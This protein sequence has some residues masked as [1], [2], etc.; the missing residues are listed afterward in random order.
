MADVLCSPSPSAVSGLRPFSIGELA[1]RCFQLYRRHFIPLFYF[2]A[3]IQAFPFSLGLILAFFDRNVQ[4]ADLQTHPENLAWFLG[5]TLLS[6]VLLTLGEGALTDYVSRLY[7][8][9]TASVRSSLAA[10]TRRSPA[11][12][13]SSA[14]KYVFIF[15]AF[16]PCL[17]P[18]ILGQLWRGPLSLGMIAGLALLG[19]LLFMPCLVLT[20]RYWVMMQAV[21]LEKLSGRATLRRSSEIVRY[22]LSKNILQ[23]GETRL[24]WI[25]LVI[26]VAN[27]LVLIACNLPQLVAT[28]AEMLR[29][30]LN[31]ETITLSP[32]I[33][34]STH[35]LNFLGGSLI[36]P[37]SV[38]GGTLFYY[39]VRVRKEAYDLELLANALQP[40]TI[41]APGATPR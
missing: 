15:L 34:A 14:L 1:D 5:R 17:I 3:L 30:N 35:L 12:L 21:M 7:L 27:V 37:L 22:N 11:L 31:P 9:Q 16:L 33:V 2:S 40:S 19:F 13:W 25:L 28:A 20:V 10:M 8:G 29:G 36:Q 4:L 23:W 18:M 24:S 26:G 39:D 38:I 41:T 6:L 32:L